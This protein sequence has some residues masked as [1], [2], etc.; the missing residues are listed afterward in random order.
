MI[1]IGLD[2]SMTSTGVTIYDVD[3]NTSS[4]YIICNKITNKSLKYLQSLDFITPICLEKRICDKNADSIQ[5]ESC[6]TFNIYNIVSQLELIVKRHRPEIAC[7]EGVS[8]GSS[9]SVVDLAGLNYA[10]R[11]MLL[12]NGVKEVKVIPPTQNKKLATGNG[13][14]DKT[15]MISAWKKMDIRTAT[16]P[17]YVKID[18]VADSYFLARLY[19]L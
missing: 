1:T 16:M 3:N 10:V 13:S 7:I 9:G 17:E 18:D 19:S 5:K 6:K 2:L 12:N 11:I 14:A 4:Y 15:L 8:F